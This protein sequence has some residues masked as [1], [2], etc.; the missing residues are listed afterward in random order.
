VAE[1]N[2]VRK[3]AE[4]NVH[5]ESDAVMKLTHING[6]MQ[7]NAAGT[8]GDAATA[9]KISFDYTC[10]EKL[11]KTETATDTHMPEK[12]YTIVD[13]M[14]EGLAGYI[15][16]HYKVNPEEAM[17]HYRMRGTRKGMEAFVQWYTG[18]SMTITDMGPGA[19][20]RAKIQKKVPMTV[21]EDRKL[22]KAIRFIKPAW[23]QA[24]IEIQ[25]AGRTE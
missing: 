6:M 10:E 5:L 14:P 17:A 19:V 20:C 18:C 16:K 15:E 22:E 4:G 7:L 3:D 25:D 8:Y 23:M 1:G 12:A 11:E 21:R 13:K 9:E 24:Q 2:G